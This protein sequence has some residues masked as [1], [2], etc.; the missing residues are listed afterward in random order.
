M[1]ISSL[2]APD[3]FIKIIPE[4]A[5]MNCD[6]SPLVVGLEAIKFDA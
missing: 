5:G 6:V 3:Y 4:R 1:A 2:E